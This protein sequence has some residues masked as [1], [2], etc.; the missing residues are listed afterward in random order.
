M[1][2][3]ISVNGMAVF[4]REEGRPS[5]GKVG[6]GTI[7]ILHGWGS[8]SDTWENVQLNL[9]SKGYHVVVPDL[10]GFGQTPQPPHPW[11]L[12]EY[13]AFVDELARLL[14]FEQFTLAGHSF[15]G[16]IAIDY[17]IRHPERL[18]SLILCDTA[19][20]TRR[21]KLKTKIFLVLTKGGN[22]IFSLPPLFLLKPLVIKVWYRVAGEKDYYRASPL[23]R[24]IMKKVMDEN[25][26]PYLPHITQP[27]LILWGED[28][29]AT[30]V[31]DAL[32]IHQ[33]IPLTHLHIFPGVGHAIQIKEPQ[34]VAKQII[35]FLNI[36]Q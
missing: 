2:N 30:P 25:I 3:T 1:Q 6:N 23:M 35:H 34:N 33:S 32:I 18:R 13:S 26:R 21:K 31:S 14:G 36:Y 17:A 8:K 28:D 22:L 16:R 9:V 19:G 5:D 29:M 20:I 10:P 4:Y 15:G 27:T 24:K 7:L 11:S 12:K